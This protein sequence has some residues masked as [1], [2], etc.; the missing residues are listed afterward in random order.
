MRH[1]YPL[2]SPEVYFKIATTWSEKNNL[3]KVDLG[4][5]INPYKNFKTVDLKGSCDIKMDLNKSWKFKTNSVGVFRAKDIIE[6]LKNPIHTMNE[7][8]RCL[9]PGGF[10]YIEVPSTDGRGAFQDPTHVSFWNENSFWY[11]TNK[12]TR[13][14]IEPECKCLFDIIK[15][16]TC[17]PNKEAQKLDI[18]YVVAYLAANK[19][20]KQDNPLQRSQIYAR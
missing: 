18:P 8:Y 17:Y 12:Q 19:V 3:L 13:K 2:R 10:L 11:Y 9:A 6:H 5:S 4:G 16:E 14:F 15:L 7:A 1:T 20:K